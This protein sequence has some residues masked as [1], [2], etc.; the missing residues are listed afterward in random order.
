MRDGIFG[1]GGALKA[2]LA[3]KKCWPRR[4]ACRR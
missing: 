1:G 4:E 3:A 2:M